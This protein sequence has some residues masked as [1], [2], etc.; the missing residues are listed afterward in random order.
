MQRS[1][2]RHEFLARLP[3]VDRED[4]DIEGYC[5]IHKENLFDLRDALL[6]WKADGVVIFPGAISETVLDSFDH[7]LEKLIS[8]PHEF[9]QEVKVGSL[10]KHTAECTSEELRQCPNLRFNNIH[11]ISPAARTLGLS[12]AVVRFLHHVFQ[13]TPCTMQT[14]T[15]NRGSQQPAHA[16]FAF[17]YNQKDIAFLA[18]SWIPLEDVHQDSG[19]LAYYP[20]THNV[21]KFGFYDFGEGEI[22]MTDGTNLMSATEFG[23]WLNGEIDRGKYPRRVFLPKRGD[24]LIWH[25]ALVHEGSRINNNALTRKSLVTHYSGMSQMPDTHVMQDT[26][27][28]PEVLAVNGGVVYKHPWVDYG[29]Q[30][31]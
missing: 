12:P 5:R 17:V 30:L 1:V 22:I 15:F 7:E 11:Y 26:R 18:A 27:G 13:E 25:A 10:S 3:W 31:Q 9:H 8:A 24:V 4:A 19:P 2:K 21:V 28:M 20:G 23:V 16:D 14:L 29:R 6:S